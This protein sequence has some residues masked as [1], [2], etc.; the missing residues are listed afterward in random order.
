MKKLNDLPKESQEALLNG[1]SMF[2][3]PLKRQD[4]ESIKNYT[5]LCDKNNSIP[6]FKPLIDYMP[7]YERGDEVCIKGFKI[8]DDMCKKDGTLWKAIIKDIKVSKLYDLANIIHN[9]EAGLKFI[10]EEETLRYWYNQQY[11]DFEDNPYVILYEIE[12]IN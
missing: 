5:W 9:D 4:E 2:V 3:I 8:N 7:M 6:I 1:A 10:S 12:R 11:N